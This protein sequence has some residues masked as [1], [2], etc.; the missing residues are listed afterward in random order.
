MMSQQ[1]SKNK[2]QEVYLKH[3]AWSFFFALN[4][5]WGDWLNG[6]S[7]MSKKNRPDKIVMPVTP[8][9]AGKGS[10]GAA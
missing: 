4:H 10:V 9:K 1:F 6:E 5:L 2:D 3:E 8:F 7:L